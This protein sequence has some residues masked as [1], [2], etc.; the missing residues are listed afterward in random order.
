[1]VL[2]GN[3]VESMENEVG[4]VLES[5]K[6]IVENIEILSSTS[7]QVSQETQSSK[8]TIDAAFDSLNIFA[9]TLSEAMEKLENLK[10]AVEV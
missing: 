6:V 7:E 1:M 8:V 9:E 10:Q 4:K 2:L 3:N 5:N